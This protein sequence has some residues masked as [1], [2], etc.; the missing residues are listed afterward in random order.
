M[1]RCNI[2]GNDTSSSI[3]SDET[4]DEY[5]YDL[6]KLKMDLYNN[7]TL[8]IDRNY[9]GHMNYTISSSHHDAM[10]A[11]LD[12]NQNQVAVES[13]PESSRYERKFIDKMKE[14][15]DYSY[16]SWGYV[17]TGGTISNIMGLWIARDKAREER[18]PNRIVLT[19]KH[20]HYNIKKACKLLYLK[21]KL[22]ECDEE[23]RMILPKSFTGVLAIVPTIGTTE[24]GTV[25]N[26]EEIIHI[27]RKNDIY[28]H[29]DAAWGGYFLYA[30]DVL[31]EFTY[32]QL[33]ML[34]KCDSVTLD[35]HKAGYAH[36]V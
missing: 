29:A 26:L 9:Q 27:A 2:F 25:D 34:S 28:V 22:C 1:N 11:A 12:Y 15:I 35:P 6:E 7:S 5:N 4:N 24:T 33:R 17:S 14:L 3:K 30:K 18:N 8:F 32:K 13:S 10:I 16:S 36:M 23:G 20:A 21:C 31:N 19:S